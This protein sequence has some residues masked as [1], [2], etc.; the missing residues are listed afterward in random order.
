MITRSLT[1]VNRAPWKRKYA[2]GTAQNRIS[3]GWMTAVKIPAWRT[4]ST[5]AA[6]PATY[7]VENTMVRSLPEPASNAKPTAQPVTARSTAAHHGTP[8]IPGIIE[9]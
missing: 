8:G 2:P 4:A 5:A 6:Q 7:S 1:P 3:G 9:R